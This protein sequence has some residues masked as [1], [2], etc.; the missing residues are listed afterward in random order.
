MFFRYRISLDQLE[1]S[2][3][4][5]RERFSFIVFLFSISIVRVEISSNM[6]YEKNIQE[7]KTNFLQRTCK[8]CFQ[9]YIEKFTIVDGLISADIY[10]NFQCTSIL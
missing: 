1:C 6:F 2:T 5:K 7:T 4:K 8:F 3:E 9:M 10:H